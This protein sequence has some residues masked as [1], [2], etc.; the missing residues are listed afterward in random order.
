M[1]EV[2]AWKEIS[3]VNQKHAGDFLEWVKSNGVGERRQWKYKHILANIAAKVGEGFRK[4]SEKD[5]GA[6]VAWLESSDYQP[7]T[8]RDYKVAF[9][10]FYK[11][12]EG[13][14]KTCPPKVEWITTGAKRRDQRLP[15]ILSEEEIKRMV[16]AAP[17][18]RDKALVSFLYE[19]GARVGE[20]LAMKCRDVVF[21]EHGALAMLTGLE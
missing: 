3:A 4:A 21:D 6:Y 16:T 20:L 17:S 11:W 8:R 19:S 5:V 7:W 14:G 18:I 13:K 1:H 10:V 9:K 2:G 12:L 15:E